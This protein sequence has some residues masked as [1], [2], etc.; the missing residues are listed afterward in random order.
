MNM[1]QKIESIFE[2]FRIFDD[3]TTSLDIFE[4]SISDFDLDFFNDFDINRWRFGNE[5]Q[6]ESELECYL[7]NSLMILSEKKMNK[8]FDILK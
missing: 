8:S 2:E 4:S 5:E 7:K 3:I 6:N 1:R